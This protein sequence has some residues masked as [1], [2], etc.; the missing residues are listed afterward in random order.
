MDAAGRTDGWGDRSEL[1]GG[2]QPVSGEVRVYRSIRSE[3]AVGCLHSIGGLR[4][5]NRA[6]LMNI[7]PGDA[8]IRG[9]H[10]RALV[11]QSLTV[12]QSGWR[13]SEG[14]FDG[15]PLCSSAGNARLF[16]GL[17][18]RSCRWRNGRI[19][20]RFCDCLLG[21]VYDLGRNC[22]LSGREHDDRGPSQSI[23]SGS[24]KSIGS[25]GNEARAE[26]IDYLIEMNR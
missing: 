14:R 12:A 7:Q 15:S 25:T 21:S 26:A 18:S 2:K 19:D 13:N 23:G 6:E 17:H 11:R 24:R 3:V 9:V 5:R 8:D 22:R 10:S 1:A 4:K 20:D 16:R